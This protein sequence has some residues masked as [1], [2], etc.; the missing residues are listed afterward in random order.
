MFYPATSLSHRKIFIFGYLQLL[1][2]KQVKVQKFNYV[3]SFINSLLGTVKNCRTSC[4]TVYEQ[5]IHNSYTISL[6][7]NNIL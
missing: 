1:M 3:Y 4:N 5:N 6:H 7:G 2:T